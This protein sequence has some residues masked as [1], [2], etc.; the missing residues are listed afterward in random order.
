MRQL[1]LIVFCCAK[2][3]RK[4]F[5]PM[6]IIPLTSDNN[7]IIFLERMIWMDSNVNTEG[8]MKCPQC[9]EQIGSYNW[10]G[11]GTYHFPAF[12]I[13]K[14]KIIQK[15]ELF[16]LETNE[17]EDIGDVFSHAGILTPPP[18]DERFKKLFSK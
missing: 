7:D 16:R 1:E 10:K 13:Q 3:E 17:D 8:I 9:T 14:D 12:K 2:C 18:L 15:L 5:T 11:E 4:L 6:S